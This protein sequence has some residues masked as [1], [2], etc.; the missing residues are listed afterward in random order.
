MAISGGASLVLQWLFS[1]LIWVV[2]VFAI[3]ATVIG[4]LWIRRRRKFVYQCMEVVD[5]SSGKT[6]FNLMPAG[7]FGK[8]KA[9]RGWYDYGDEQ[10]ETVDGDLINDFSTE[11]FQEINGKRAIVCAR[12]PTNAN[13][14]VPISKVSIKGKSM[15]MEIAPAD[16]QDTAARI[17]DDADRETADR[18]AQI[19]QWVLIGGTIIFA[20]VA[21]IIIAQMVK[22]GQRE[23]ANLIV[24]AGKT[25][26][27][28]AK[29]VCRTLATTAPSGGAP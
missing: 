1:P 23:A 24:E 2:I 18:V 27:E 6:G 11:D 12:S 28:N 8:K 16:Y 29:E 4:S 13:V 5:Y 9:F 25:C 26:L 21:I 7:W 15:L 3:L 22:Q 19:V 10:L 14:L 17:I 20:L